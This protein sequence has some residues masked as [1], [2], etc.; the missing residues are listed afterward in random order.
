MKTKPSALVLA[1]P[2]ALTT[3]TGCSMTDKESA[4]KTPSAGTSTSRDASDAMEKVS[5]GI[6][7]LIGVKGKA[8]NSRPGVKDCSGKD[9]KTY[10]TIFH[11]WSFYPTSASDLDEAME[12]L[13]KELPKHGWKIV[14][15]G[16]DTSKNKN[17]NLTADNDEKKVGVNIVQ[18]SK[19]DP[20]KLSLTLVSGCYKVPDGEE[21]E[22]F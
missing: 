3:L 19:N 10:F 15:Y 17:I 16:P 2:L 11:P 4:D 22:R 9:T 7:D 1:V 13:K 8:S 21:V 5:S 12:R 18:M 6:Y 20:P 14:E